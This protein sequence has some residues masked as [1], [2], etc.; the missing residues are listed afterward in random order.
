[1]AT[2]PVYWIDEDADDLIV[3]VPKSLASRE[4]ISRFLDWLEFQQLR[5][6]SELTEE[7]AAELAAEVKHAVW[8]ANGFAPRRSDCGR[9]ADRR[10][11]QHSVFG[12]PAR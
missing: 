8:E 5:S 11:H 10:R 3:R 9:G 7:D 12:T 2:Q 4:R 6:S 1:M